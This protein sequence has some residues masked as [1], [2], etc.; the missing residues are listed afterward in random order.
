LKMVSLLWL[1]YS[2]YKIQQHASFLEAKTIR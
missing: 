1:Y 2:D